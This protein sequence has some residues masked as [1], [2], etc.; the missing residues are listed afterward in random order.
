VTRDLQ[1]RTHELLMTTALPSWAY[2]W[3]RY[4][5][6]LLM[7]L[8]LA[9]LLLAAIQMMGT[10]LHFT[11]T[12]YPAPVL[13]NVLI[14]WVVMVVPATVLVSSLGFAVVTLLPRLSAMVKIVILLGWVV[15]AEVLPG[16]L[17]FPAGP[18]N[19]PAWYTAWDP[20]A[21]LSEVRLLQQ[22]EVA[23][24]QQLPATTTPAQVQHLINTVANKAPDVSALLAP[25]L[26]EALLSLALVVLAAFTFR[27]FRNIFGA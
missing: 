7:S 16:L 22:Y 2:V 8:G 13:G 26:I 14:L 9:T 19:H 27:R 4:L 23:F 6:G 20:T 24:E 11:T 18:T 21:A 15:G 12:Y 1:R 3:G 10:V 25:H 5:V 17:Y